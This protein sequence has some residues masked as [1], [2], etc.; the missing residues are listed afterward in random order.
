MIRDPK[1]PTEARVDLQD[2]ALSISKLSIGLFDAIEDG[3]LTTAAAYLQNIFHKATEIN[4]AL[5]P[6]ALAALLGV[7]PPKDPT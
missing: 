1:I 5:K 3:N 4:S 7:E 6:Y 2:G